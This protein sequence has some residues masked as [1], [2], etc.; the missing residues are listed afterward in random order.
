M[1]NLSGSMGEING[2]I[3]SM[4]G[5]TRHSRLRDQI[6]DT[7]ELYEL[8]VKHDGLADASSDLAQVINQQ[9]KRL[10][11]RSSASGRR[12]NWASL[13]VCWVIAGLLS[14]GGY[15]LS[16]HW[17]SWWGTLLMIIDVFVGVLFAVAGVGTLLEPKS[18][19][20]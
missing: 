15:A 10:L 6:R 19:A 18:E 8:T 11:E 17:G 1:P 3:R 9:A 20:A 7:T 16:S 12:W 4:L 5:L 13:I 2:M 14:L